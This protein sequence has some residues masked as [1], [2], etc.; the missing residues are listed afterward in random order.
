MANANIVFGEC[1]RELSTLLERYP[2]YELRDAILRSRVEPQFFHTLPFQTFGSGISQS[3]LVHDLIEHLERHGLL[4][5]RNETTGLLFQS[6]LEL[7]PGLY[8]ELRDVARFFAVELAPIDPDTEAA[9]PPPIPAELLEGRERS[10]L[11]DQL[12][13]LLVRRS[14][15][16]VASRESEQLR[17]EANALARELHATGGV[18]RGQRVA[19]TLLEEVLGSGSFGTVWRARSA[20]TGGVVATKVFHLDKLGQ[21]LM[22]PRFRRSI[23]ML[24]LLTQD[25]DC[26]ASITRIRDVSDDGLAFSMDYAHCGTLETIQR[27]KWTIPVLLEKF[28]TICEACHFAHEKGII[29]RDIKPGNIL[30]NEDLQPRL[31]DFDISDAL[32]SRIDYLGASTQGWLGTPVFGA[33]EQLLEGRNASRQSD[34]Y[35]LG[36][37][38][39]FM[40]LGGISPGMLT[41][42]E[43][44]LEDLSA[45]PLPIVDIVRKATRYNPRRRYPSVRAMIQDIDRC[46][47]GLAA[48]RARLQLAYRWFKRNRT[49]LGVLAVGF[50]AAAAV[51]W[52]LDR[53]EHQRLQ[54]VVEET[55]RLCIE[56]SLHDGREGVRT[57][58][59]TTDE[60][61]AHYD[62][63]PPD[64]TRAAALDDLEKRRTILDQTMQTFAMLEASYVG[65]RVAD[66]DLGSILTT[67]PDWR[68]ALPP[69]PPILLPESSLYCA[70]RGPMDCPT[71]RSSDADKKPSSQPKVTRSN[72]IAS[73]TPIADRPPL[74]KNILPEILSDIVTSC[75]GKAW[76]MLSFTLGVRKQGDRVDA[77]Q[78]EPVATHPAITCA[79][80]MIDARAFD[81]S[82]IDENT[83]FVWRIDLVNPEAPSGYV[84]SYREMDRQQQRSRQLDAKAAKQPRE[85]A[86]DSF[87]AAQGEAVRSA[88]TAMK[89]AEGAR[90][91]RP[92]HWL[93][94]YAH[95]ATHAIQEYE[96][97][98]HYK[99]EEMRRYVM[100]R[101]VAPFCSRDL[102][103]AW[104]VAK[105]ARKLLQTTAW[106]P[107]FANRANEHEP[108][109][110]FEGRCVADD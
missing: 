20:V 99:A 65:S 37:L 88:R 61:R 56:R 96:H 108:F 82:R 43:P 69:L 12:E 14:N 109:K 106:A 32:N 64:E 100:L 57:E 78:H 30:L 59:Q 52:Y 76:P 105:E 5:A 34:V 92:T 93:A 38:L 26:P 23:Q 77:Q 10:R 101:P 39:H 110:D 28:R 91:A 95:L 9:E 63:L 21:G 31:I 50:A 46:H 55:M 44:D 103:D 58:L 36:R 15:V 45:V 18:R 8:R 19:G 87:K 1:Y 22:L 17:L 66:G 3:Q 27:F 4:A 41:E 104:G 13:Q 7:R 51:W 49:P 85:E 60:R 102:A 74:T 107:Y 54:G 25:L 29:H 67:F 2:F 90:G 98:H 97:A 47:T 79:I 40:L 73:T 72:A 89:I 33:P 11:V 84:E 94:D 53:L 83:R 75:A 24:R 71:T 86:R 68:A 35:S 6:L 62:A 42:H 81:L 48:V 70:D 16:G 80:Q